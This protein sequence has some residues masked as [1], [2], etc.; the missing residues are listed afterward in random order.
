MEVKVNKIFLIKTIQNNVKLTRHWFV[1][2]KY[3]E[4]FECML[5]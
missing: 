5:I 2:L 1:N 4:Y 3:F